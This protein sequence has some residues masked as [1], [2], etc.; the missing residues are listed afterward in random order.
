MSIH[1]NA[2]E[3]NDVTMQRRLSLAWRMY[4]MI[5]GSR[6]YTDLGHGH[7]CDGLQMT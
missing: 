7:H 3:S 5:P 6:A 1:Q 4:K 2:H